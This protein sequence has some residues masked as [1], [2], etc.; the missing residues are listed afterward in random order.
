MEQDKIAIFL[1]SGK[2]GKLKELLGSPSLDLRC[3]V[4]KYKEKESM[5]NGWSHF[6]IYLYRFELLGPSK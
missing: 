1:S 5:K 3:H 2:T 4:Q 6:L